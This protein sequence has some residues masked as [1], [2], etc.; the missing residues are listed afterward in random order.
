MITVTLAFS[1]SMS[2]FIGRVGLSMNLSAMYEHH[3]ALLE[4]LR[5]KTL[6]YTI[7]CLRLNHTAPH[8]VALLLHCC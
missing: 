7:Q 1:P 6:V 3:T 8:K 5:V 4:K 2:C